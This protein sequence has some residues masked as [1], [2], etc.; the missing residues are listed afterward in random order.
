MLPAC[1][2]ATCSLKLLVNWGDS[3]TKY[4][5]NTGL[6]STSFQALITIFFLSISCFLSQYHMAI[7]SH[8]Q[9]QWLKNNNINFLIMLYMHSEY[10]RDCALCPYSTFEMARA[11]TNWATTNGGSRRKQIW[12]LVPAIKCLVLKWHFLL[13]HNVLAKTNSMVSPTQRK[14]MDPRVYKVENWD[15][16]IGEQSTTIIK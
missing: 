6:A 4:F 5:T 15:K 13:P 9:W 8:N 16:V 11:A 2:S 7:L 14:A 12:G 3:F 10:T 1:F